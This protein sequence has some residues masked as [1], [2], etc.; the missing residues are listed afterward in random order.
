M[1]Q[2]NL[3]FV[4]VPKCAH[5]W[6]DEVH[7]GARLKRACSANNLGPSWPST[8]WHRR[9]RAVDEQNSA[10]ERAAATGRTAIAVDRVPAIGDIPR[11]ARDPG[12]G[13]ADH[14]L[15]LAVAGAGMTSVGNDFRTAR[16]PLLPSD[17][18][19]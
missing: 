1:K 16:E 2:R 7:E 3:R 9:S 13:R 4:I 11:F 19:A 10:L 18:L 12:I 14:S 17:W 6:A 5:P 15:R 8:T